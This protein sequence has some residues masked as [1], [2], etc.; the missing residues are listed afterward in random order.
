MHE[1]LVTDFTSC[2]DDSRPFKVNIYTHDP[3]V[4]WD[5]LQVLCH[6]HT[7]HP[8]ELISKITFYL[9][10]LIL[11]STFLSLTVVWSDLILIYTTII[12]RNDK[13]EE[14]LPPTVSFSLSSCTYWKVKFCTPTLGFTT[15][16][17]N[18]NSLF[19]QSARRTIVRDS[20]CIVETTQVQ[21]L[22]NDLD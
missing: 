15:S 21:V 11:V 20:S 19:D 18:V 16:N 7:H 10:N 8:P 3:D 5:M 1:T 13:S 4:S 12:K 22:Q 6:L 14:G 17:C 2:R 9:N